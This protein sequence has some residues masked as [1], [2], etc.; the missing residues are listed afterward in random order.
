MRKIRTKI[1]SPDKLSARCQ[2]E[3]GQLCSSFQWLPLKDLA[4]YTPESDTHF[5]AVSFHGSKPAIVYIH[6]LADSKVVE[7]VGSDGQEHTVI[8][9]WEAGQFLKCYGSCKVGEM[10]LVSSQVHCR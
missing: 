3:A 10:K 1:S 8:I 5:L 9:T 7:S 2:E 4:V 6:Q